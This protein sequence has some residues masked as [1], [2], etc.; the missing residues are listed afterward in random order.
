MRRVLYPNP[1]AFAIN[2]LLKGPGCNLAP[3][4]ISEKVNAP[5]PRQAAG[6]PLAPFDV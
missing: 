3:L 1:H 2:G 5:T 6:L 4:G